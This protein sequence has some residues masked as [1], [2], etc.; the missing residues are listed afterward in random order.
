MIVCKIRSITNLNP[1]EIWPNTL[2]IKQT[3]IKLKWD[4]IFS[5]Q[6]CEVQNTCKIHNIDK[7]IERLLLYVI[8]L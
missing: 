2:I 1:A 7:G 4:G 8:E 3:L 5:N 6:F